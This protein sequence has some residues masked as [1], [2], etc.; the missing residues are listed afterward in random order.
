MRK[1]TFA[2]AAGLIALAGCGG[3]DQP[4]GNGA[5]AAGG[6]SAAP[7][8]SSAAAQIDPGEWEVAFETSMTGTGLPPA[9]LEAMKSHK[10]TKR[11]CITPEQ[12]RRP[13]DTDR[14]KN[15]D[16]SKFSMGG[17]RISGIVTCNGG[18]NKATMAMEG[19]FTPQTYEYT[20]TM[21]NKGQGADLTTRIRAVGHRVG[22]CKA[23]EA[24]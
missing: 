3:K 20:M 2:A 18:G 23:G 11:Q 5:A 19:Q 21:N 16:Y 24:E 7:A 6:G 14:D 8:A 9:A 1:T 13:M 15:C 12:A 4:A 17:G 10:E 22:D